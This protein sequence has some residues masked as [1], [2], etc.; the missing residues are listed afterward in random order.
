VGAWLRVA[1]RIQ[2]ANSK[3]L[4]GE[5]MDLVYGELHAGGR[6][7]KNVSL[8]FNVNATGLNGSGLSMDAGIEDAIIGFDFADPIHLWIGQLLVPVDRANYGGPFFNVAWNYPGIW[9]AGAKTVFALPKEGPGGYGRDTGASLWGDI[10]GGKFN[11]KLGVFQSG[12]LSTSPLFSGRL[13]V[14]VVGEET[15][16]FGNETYFGDKDIVSIGLGG[17]Y[18]KK[19]TVGLTPTAAMG[20]GAAP[21]DNYAEVN[22]DVLGEVKYGGGGWITGEAAYYH[23]AGDFNPFKDSFYV[24]GAIATP[25]VGLGNIQPMVRYQLASGDGPKAWAVD[26]FVSY[27]IMGPALKVMAGFQHTDVGNDTTGNAIQLAAQGIFF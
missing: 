23:Y 7:H 13:S 6:I 1:A 4:D 19:G 22:A 12:S 27:L 15:G 11:Y 24:L 26:A 16:Y 18:Q 14:A 8:T 20:G 21:T 3:D 5:K 25:K 2:G 9:S 17:Q 10:E